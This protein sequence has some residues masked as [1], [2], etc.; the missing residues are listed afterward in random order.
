VVQINH[1]LAGRDSHPG[2]LLPTL[3]A[4]PVK[5]KEITILGK[6]YMLLESIP[7][8]LTQLL[9]VLGTPN[10]VCQKLLFGLGDRRADDGMEKG[11]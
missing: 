7:I 9:E 2:R 5:T 11:A 4:K 6:D 1:R 10:A 3:G 8:Y